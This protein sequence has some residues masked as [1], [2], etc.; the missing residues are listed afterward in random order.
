MKILTVKELINLLQKCPE[1]AVVFG[2]SEMDEGD[3][4]AQIVEFVDGIL[5]EGEEDV[6]IAP[7]YCQADS[8][9]VDYWRENG[10]K[11]IVY[12]RPRMWGDC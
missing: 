11:P 3:F 4:P 8:T 12:I 7:H 6:I 2:Y 10:N 9:V 5:P 1:E